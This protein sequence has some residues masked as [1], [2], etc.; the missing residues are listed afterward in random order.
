MAYKR[1]FL[2]CIVVLI[3][4]ALFVSSGAAANQIKNGD[5]SD[6]SLYWQD[7]SGVTFTGGEAIFSVSGAG[8]YPATAYM[9]QTGVDLTNVNTLTFRAKFDTSSTLYSNTLTLILSKPGSTSE[10]QTY[11]LQGN[12]DT[13][14]F[15]T[16]SLTGKY[17]VRFEYTVNGQTGITWINSIRADDV[18]AMTLDPV[19]VGS[20]SVSPTTQNAGRYVTVSATYSGGSQPTGAGQ[21]YVRIEVYN[22]NSAY[23][24]GE[25]V[26]IYSLGG[27]DVTWVF[28]PGTNA[29]GTCTIKA[30]GV[31]GDRSPVERTTTLT[32]LSPVPA[33]PILMSSDTEIEKDSS[34]IF[35]FGAGQGERVT[36][37]KFYPLGISGTM[38]DYTAQEAT[39]GIQFTYTTPGVYQAVLIAVGDGGD[40]EQSNAV[41]IRVGET[42][43]SIPNPTYYIGQDTSFTAS[44]SISPYS[45]LDSYS[46]QWWLLNTY[47]QPV[48]QITTYQISSATGT[49][50]ISIADITERGNYALLLVKGNGLEGAIAS[51]TVEIRYAGLQLTVNLVSGNNPLGNTATVTLAAGDTVIDTKTTNSGTVF[52]TPVTA[53]TT[54]TITANATGF[55][56]QVKSLVMPSG[57]TTVQIDFGSSGSSSGYGGQYEPAAATIMVTSEYGVALENVYVKIQGIQNSFTDIGW[58]NAIYDFF[59]GAQ[60]AEEEQIQVTDYYGKAVFIVIPNQRYKVTFTY[61]GVTKEEQFTF[62]NGLTVRYK[63]ET[64]V[65]QTNLGKYFQ[66]TA[67]AI[68]GIISAT[69][70]NTHGT[71]NPYLTITVKDKDGNT[72]GQSWSGTVLDTYTAT[73][74][75]GED[76]YNSEYSV[77]FTAATPIGQ[78]EKKVD[79]I[80]N[81]PRLDL[82]LPPALLIWIAVF[83]AF[84]IGGVF[85]RIT[86]SVGCLAVSIWLWICYGIGWLWQLEDTIGTIGLVTCLMVAT[87]LSLGFMFAEAR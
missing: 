23:V 57:D 79:V 49:Q 16:S 75:V 19:T 29:V 36:G 18:S 54:Y 26:D 82:G 7:N 78:W 74:E 48:T 72:V 10:Q 47:G 40:S 34:V 35:Q 52:F 30:Y 38:Y 17:T 59:M 69:F 2:A 53:G 11:S 63:F 86:A 24:G 83:L 8:Y 87:V 71:I 66:G 28:T 9:Q 67:T 43:V 20:V 4:F 73:W 37:W 50:T 12:Y 25:N 60:L 65:E 13:Y 84:A 70:T 5:F 1:L 15:D 21:S 32:V 85:S 76:Y 56:E 41:T 51:D 45:S 31:A 3:F 81:G 22:S 44:Y 58:V 68:D 64:G 80:F 55:I 77:Y 61:N 33:K 6:G 62:G 46:L 27:N 39:G 14:S 42:Y